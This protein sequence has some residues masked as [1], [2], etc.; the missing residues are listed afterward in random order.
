[1][2]NSVCESI[3]KPKKDAAKHK[4]N[5]RSKKAKRDDDVM[6]VSFHAHG[7]EDSSQEHRTDIDIRLMT[8]ASSQ[9]DACLSCTSAASQTSTSRS[10]P[11]LSGGIRSSTADI[12]CACM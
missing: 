7:H 8:A 9:K 6:N 10:H 4:G 11:S 1:M 5:M 3:M 12:G 2:R